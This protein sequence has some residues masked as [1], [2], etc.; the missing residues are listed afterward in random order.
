MLN[1]KNII[2]SGA[3]RGI[4][5]VIVEECARNH[6]NV[7][8]CMRK[9]S[10]DTNKWIHQIKIENDVIVEPIILNLEN[11]NS[12][13]EAG[14]C[15]LNEKREIDGIV[16]NA[17][18]TGSKALFS[19]TTMEDIRNTFEVNFFGPMFFTQ[20][21][22]KRII[23]QKNCSIVNISSVA[24]FDGDPGQLGY[25]SSKS[26]INGAT[27]KLSLELGQFGIRVNAIAPGMTKTTMAEEIENK[28]RDDA[29]GRTA[30]GRMAEPEEVAKLCVYLLSDQ[31]S[32]V[33]GQIIRID[34]GSI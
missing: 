30:L 4:G 10:E 11:E 20:R 7:W 34:G 28:I 5:K 14:S 33:T 19:M 29:L 8:A 13:R 15:I 2:V 25:V 1:G 27:K 9:V 23:R 24:S 12:I 6:A 3:N 22:L 16:N 31:S 17:G 18:I 32:Y 21:F 26:A